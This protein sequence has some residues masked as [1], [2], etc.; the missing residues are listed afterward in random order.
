MCKRYRTL[1]I[2]SNTLIK[3]VIFTI[4]KIK[5]E[6]GDRSEPLAAVIVDGDLIVNHPRLSQFF[7]ISVFTLTVA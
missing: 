3:I 1:N 7:L 2:K 5:P 6:K 4:Q